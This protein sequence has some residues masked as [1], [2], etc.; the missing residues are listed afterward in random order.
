M[1]VDYRALAISG[2][3]AVLVGGAFS[4]PILF[5]AAFADEP[6][7]Y[8][9]MTLDELLPRPVKASDFVKYAVTYDDSVSTDVERTQI[10]DKISFGRRTK[11]TIATTSSGTYSSDALTSRYVRYPGID[12]AALPGDGPSHDRFLF[13]STETPWGT[14]VSTGISSGSFVY[15]SSTFTPKRR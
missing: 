6:A 9:V 12:V 5:P 10:V 3:L 13:S 4:T 11:V 15:Y 8:A 1:A 7:H 2:T 14:R